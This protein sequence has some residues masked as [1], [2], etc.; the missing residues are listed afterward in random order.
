MVQDDLADW[1]SLAFDY[2]DLH[3]RAM[4]V[5]MSRQVHARPELLVR[6]AGIG[7]NKKHRRSGRVLYERHCL[8]HCV[9]SL[10]SVPPSDQDPPNRIGRLSSGW[11]NVGAP[12]TLE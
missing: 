12:S 9:R 3:L 8:S 6:S 11:D 5:E 2:L 4:S 10:A 7:V 1:S